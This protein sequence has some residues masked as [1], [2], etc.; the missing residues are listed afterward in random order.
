MSL[1]DRPHQ[2]VWNGCQ[3]QSTPAELQ[4]VAGRG[5]AAHSS[6][7]RTCALAPRV[8]R[9]DALILAAGRSRRGR[10]GRRRQISRPATW[11]H[12]VFCHT[13]E[14]CGLRQTA[15]SL[16]LCRLIC[17]VRKIMIMSYK[18]LQ[19][20]TM[21]VEPMSFA[22]SIALQI[23]HL[24]VLFSTHG[25]FSVWKTG[26]CTGCQSGVCIPGHRPQ[27]SNIC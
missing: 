1:W 23:T 17:Q 13:R 12:T 22:Q 8:L 18:L 11:L 27:I 19:V 6:H 26:Q 9:V 2:P 21:R 24:Y 15:P 14:L 10:R 20:L 3:A 16:S 5:L 7:Q 25:F 4:G